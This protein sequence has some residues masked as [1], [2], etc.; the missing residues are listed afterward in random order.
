M[1]RS[2]PKILIIT[3]P[4]G[5]GRSTAINALEDAGYETIDNLPLALLPR[6]L[7]GPKPTRNLALAIDI[8]TRDFSVKSVMDAL[9]HLHQIEGIESSLVFLDCSDEVLLRRYSETRRR[10]PTSPDGEPSTGISIEKDLLAALKHRADVVIETT[11]LSPH[12][13]KSE[14]QSLFATDGEAT[15]AINLQSFSY[16]RG[17]PR[18]ID[19]AFDC[20]FLKNPYWDESLRERTGKDTA[21]ID[22]IRQDP[23][24]DSFLGQL[25]GLLETLLPAYKE[26]GKAHLTIG[27]GCTGG[28]HR[29]VYV[30]E[31][32]GRAL[33]KVGWHTQVRHRELERKASMGVNQ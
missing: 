18:G 20:R 3:C 5:A 11:D 4:S 17:M 21:V 12:Q 15:L 29:S 13:L 16:K 10:H 30:A 2:E 28:Q 33:E 26:E 8:R 27:L 9:D 25:T 7:D 6:L 23:R 31:A 19:M 24:L 14:I 22:Y 32:L 1:S